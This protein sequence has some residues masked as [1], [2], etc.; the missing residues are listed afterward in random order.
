M[1]RAKPLL[2]IL[3]GIRQKEI[4]NDRSAL[5][6]SRAKRIKDLRDLHHPVLRISIEDTLSR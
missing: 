2:Q 1:H 4:L 6:A 5:H 3:V